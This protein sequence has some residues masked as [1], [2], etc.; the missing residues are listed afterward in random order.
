MEVNVMEL[1]KFYKNRIKK[2]NSVISENIDKTLVMDPYLDIKKERPI[3][4]IGEAP[5]ETEVEL[6]QP[7][8]GPSGQNLIHLISFFKMSREKDFLI[9]N[10]FPFR[11]RIRG[12]DKAWKNRTPS[13]EELKIGSELLLEEIKLVKPSMIIL[14]GGTATTGIRYIK[15]LDIA[16]NSVERGEIKEFEMYGFKVKI[17]Y[18]FHPSPIAYNR[19]SIKEDLF[20]FFEKIREES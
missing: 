15:E 12:I 3:M 17:G 5:G 13:R 20:K 16:V 8:C 10:I 11:T 18:S 9:T 7:F 2:I 14:L 4:I 19:P 1:L 6:G